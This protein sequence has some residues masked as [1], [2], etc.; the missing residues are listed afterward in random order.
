MIMVMVIIMIMIMVMIMIKIKIMIM[1]III[2]KSGR[3]ECEV[4]SLIKETRYSNYWKIFGNFRKLSETFSE[5][6]WQ[7][8]IYF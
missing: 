3:S 7:F 2:I 1:T 8:L 4:R 5:S 6:F